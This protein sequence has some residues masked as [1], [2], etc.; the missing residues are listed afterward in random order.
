MTR[1]ATARKPAA[2]P[3]AAFPFPPLAKGE[4]YAGVL[5]AGDK[6]H[7]LVLLPGDEQK[8]WKDAIAWA[9]KL[10]G[11]LPT[12]KEQ[13]LLFANAAGHFQEHWYWSSETHARDADYA[14]IQTF[15]DGFQL[16]DRKYDDSRCR[17]VRR[18]PI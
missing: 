17:A 8:N 1:T 11:G 14:W 13:A 16:Y 9:K 10:G 7:H 6:M 18:V 4:V 2:A 5:I 12:R 3:A 15:S